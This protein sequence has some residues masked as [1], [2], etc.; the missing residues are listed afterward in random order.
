MN[1]WTSFFVSPSNTSL[2]L[3]ERNG[4]E[5]EKSISLLSSLRADFLRHLRRGSN[6]L[7]SLFGSDLKLRTFRRRPK[8]MTS[9]EPKRQGLMDFGDIHVSKQ[10]SKWDS[11]C[12]KVEDALRGVNPFTVKHQEKTWTKNC[13]SSYWSYTSGRPSICGWW[14]GEKVPTGKV[15]MNLAIQGSKLIQGSRSVTSY[16]MVD[17]KYMLYN[18]I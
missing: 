14:S 5:V 17:Q 15:P 1:P 18:C 3:G 9:I 13:G 6:K 10:L 7:W 2:N 16:I 12:W 4:R 11:L 8:N